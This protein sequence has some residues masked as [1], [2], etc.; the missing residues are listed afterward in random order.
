MT[1]TSEPAAAFEPVDS[2][3]L[4]SVLGHFAT[5]VIA[6]TAIDPDTGKGAGLAANSFT[7]VSLDPPLVAFCVAHS[8]GSWPA[9]KRAEK[10]VI[11]ILAEDQEHVGRQLAV[12]GGDK[13][14]GLDWSPS[15]N[16]API[17]DNAVA[18]IEAQVDAEHVAGDH[19]IVVS[20]VNHLYADG[21]A[22]L[23]FHKGKY[24]RL[25]SE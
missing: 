3:M 12:K 7:S 14:A 4:R 17:L 5:G 9:V 15:P 21:R 6:I 18:W 1:T 2:T 16:G 10:F 8:S 22:P 24:S 25:L 19:V 20:R 11:N 13:F 23:L